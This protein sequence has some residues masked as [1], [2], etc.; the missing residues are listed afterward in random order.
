MNTPSPSIIRR[1]DMGLAIA[2]TRIT[3]YTIMEYLREGWSQQNMSDWLNLTTEQIQVA[4]DY[5][6]AHRSEVEAEYDEVIRET[7]ER[8]HYWE[9]RLQKHLAHQ[10]RSQPSPDKAALYAKL[11][12]QRAQTI[13][14]YVDDIG[15]SSH[16]T[17]RPSFPL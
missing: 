17:N 4:L 5:I 2:G 6:E 8:R 14:G 10:P 3:L 1:P 16:N 9:E 7:E 15:A 11:A 13:H 12:E